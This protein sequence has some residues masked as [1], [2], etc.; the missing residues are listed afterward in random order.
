MKKRF[1]IIFIISLAVSIKLQAA[2]EYGL[3]FKSHYHTAVERTGVSL[4]DGRPFHMKKDFTID[5]QMMLRDEPDYGIILNVTTNDSQKIHLMLAAGSDEVNYPAIVMNEGIFPIQTQ[6]R[7]EEWIPVSLHFHINENTL[8][9]RYDQCD[10][11]IIVPLK[12]TREITAS[13]GLDKGFSQEV[14][15]MNIRDVRIT[16][17]GHNIAFWKF[18]QHYG[19]VCYD[20]YNRLKATATNGIWLTDRHL[21]WDHIYTE[22]DDE[23]F[24]VTFNSRD[25]SF[26]IVKKDEVTTLI[27]G[28]EKKETSPIK[29]GFPALEYPEH[30]VFDTLSNRIFSYSLST[31]LSSSLDL[32]TGEWDQKTHNSSEPRYYN[33]ARAFNPADSCF[34]FFGG[35]GFYQYRNKLFRMDTRTGQ[36]SEV[37]YEPRIPPRYSSA[38]AIVDNE[39][40]IFGGRGNK[41]GKQELPSNYYY[42]LWKISLE[43]GQASLVWE[44]TDA[45]ENMVMASSMSY[46][47]SEKAFY[48]VSLTRGGILWKISAEKPEWIPISKAINNGSGY[49]DIDFSLY[50]APEYDKM[51]LVMNKFLP[52]HSAH[53]DIFSID[54][55]LMDEAVLP[56]VEEL[57]EEKSYIR[58]I[59]IILSAL[60][61]AGVAVMLYR[62]FTKR[63]NRAQA[64]KEEEPSAPFSSDYQTAG[65]FFDR[66]RAAVS[67]LGTF[68]VCDKEGNDITASF[69]PRL[70][71]LFIL[72]ILHSEKSPQGVLMKN[73]S[74]IIWP[75]LEEEA[76]RN[77]RN[78]TLRKLRVLLK[79]VGDI[80]I[81]TK[82]GFC[83]IEWPDDVFCDYKKALE[84]I[85]QFNEKDAQSDSVLLEQVLELL[86]FGPLLS[87]TILDW[88][89]D[90]KDAYSSLSI[91]MLRYLLKIYGNNQELTLRIIDII[92]RHDPLSE[93]AL[94]IKCSIFYS[95]GKKGLAK[96][97][98]DRFC[99]EYQASLGEEYKT[100][101]ADL[102]KESDKYY[103]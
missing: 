75:E 32:S 42:E 97:A 81:V 63:R 66:S 5:F 37:N 98:Y 12:G 92:F 88:L 52:D 28:T 59:I 6:I 87:N 7:K 74:E 84:C 83:R 93:K 18:N 22:K 86:L 57:P 13:L 15:P 62:L 45:Q 96:N 51:Y 78:V 34:Y 39:I 3:H 58:I 14:A 95:Q 2:V 76:A 101:L 56:F 99:R 90:F 77:N 17:D 36:V 26:Y 94:A 70:K 72:L 89:D 50:S 25:C 49:Q 40:Y 9:L 79:N 65:P 10:T 53:L 20:N 47:P 103:F 30:V 100:P 48:G 31:Q 71:H 29:G 35:Y 91:D 33:H 61:V 60:L 67:L 54:T 16:C 11:T 82:N 85:R 8:D 73:I 19:G 64:A 68:R 41:H 27:P 43:D 4:N 21:E 80:E 24:D 55:P 23:H 44:N 38:M 102:Y 1:I 69:T 46:E